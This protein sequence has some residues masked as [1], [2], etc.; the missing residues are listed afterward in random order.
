MQITRP[1]LVPEACKP[2]QMKKRHARA[3]REKHVKSGSG[4]RDLHKVE[5][6]GGERHGIAWHCAGTQVL[7]GGVKL[8][9][10][11]ANN[12]LAVW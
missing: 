8:A 1:P 2:W 5:L 4:V 3:G 12:P 6:L 9:A 11:T 10:D 7:A